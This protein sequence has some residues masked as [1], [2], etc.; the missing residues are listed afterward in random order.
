[1]RG[2]ARFPSSLCYNGVMKITK[3]E[4][5]GVILEKNGKKLVFDPVEFAGTLPALRDVVAI[6]ITH[7]H[8]DHLQPEKITAIMDLNP[9][10][11]I[12]APEDALDQ[13][14][15]ATVVA[16]GDEMNIEGFE[17]KFF[18]KDHASVM[19]GK[20]PCDNIGV[21]VDGKLTNP[22]DSF[23]LLELDG[24]VE[25]L[26]VPEVAPWA[27]ISETI[28]FMKIA[29]PRIVIPVHDGLLSEMG[30]EIYDRLLGGAC[31]SIGAEFAPL[32]IGESMEI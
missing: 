10:A 16:G 4:H 20:V 25:T 15:N 12:F 24:E 31:E 9:G 5:S 26:L 1:M 8:S 14:P 21:V 19:A 18:G 6:I 32:N 17:L 27:K 3:L 28:E 29:K 30:K 2:N 7:L 11:R 13:L 22:G 23:D